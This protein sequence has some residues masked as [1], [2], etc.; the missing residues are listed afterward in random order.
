ME[1]EDKPVKPCP[2]SPK[3]PDRPQ[4]KEAKEIAS[5]VS[6]ISDENFADYR[7]LKSQNYSIS[8]TDEYSMFTSEKATLFVNP[9]G[10][11]VLWPEENQTEIER[12]VFGKE[13]FVSF[14]PNQPALIRTLS[15]LF[16]CA[17][18]D[19]FKG[20]YTFGLESNV[21]NCNRSVVLKND[22]DLYFLNTANEVCHYDLSVV[23]NDLKYK[24][25][26]WGIKNIHK[27]SKR[28]KLDLKD[29][30]EGPGDKIYGVNSEGLV[31]DV[32]GGKRK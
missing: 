4:D 26:T 14:Y 27:V 32:L 19:T 10:G 6:L 16:V 29:I 22:K 13:Y 5:K 3:S 21:P 1:R 2:D 25:D 24:Q 20:Y 28:F 8:F 31:V 30:A 23:L 11:T 18:E 12:V 17:T 7:A 9:E 15:G